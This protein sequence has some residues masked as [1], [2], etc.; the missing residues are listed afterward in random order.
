[1]AIGPGQQRKHF[2][3]TLNFGEKQKHA[4][5]NIEEIEDFFLTCPDFTAFAGQL[6]AGDEGTPH[7]QF[8]LDTKKILRRSTLER[9]ILRGT[10]V[11][12][13][14]DERRGNTNYTTK[15]E[16]RLREPIRHG[17][18]HQIRKVDD[19]HTM[20]DIVILLTNGASESD[21]LNFY[22]MAYFKWGPKIRD[23]IKA[24]VRLQQ[25]LAKEEEE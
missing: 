10:G 6:E 14:L 2:F 4:L 9:I 1:M 15:T 3:G 21:I 11:R 18:V 7:F 12:P 8:V 24:R 5:E 16:G 19:K 22:P 13:W 23:F 25:A 17:R 20:Y